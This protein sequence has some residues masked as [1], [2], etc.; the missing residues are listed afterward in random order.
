MCGIIAIASRQDAVSFI[1]EGLKKLEYRGYD[2]AGLSVIED[3]TL[4][5]VKTVGKIAE[6][7]KKIN[8]L[9]ISSTIGIGHTRWATHGIPCDQNAHPH[10][11]QDQRFSIVHNGIIENYHELKNEL[12]K[13]GYQ[14]ASTT[15]S[16]VIVA[17]IQQYYQGD[18][19]STLYK[20][21]QK[22]KGSYAICALSIDEPDCLVVAKKDSPV[23]IGQNENGCF[24]ASDVM[25]LLDYTKEVYYLNDYEM[26]TLTSSKITFYDSEMKKIIK[27]KKHVPY[28]Q[29]T[30]KKEGYETYMLKEIFEQ[31]KA[32]LETLRGKCENQILLEELEEID[33]SKFNQVYYI[34]CGTAYHASL[35][36]AHLL[37]KTS[38]LPIKVQVAS[39]FRY[40]EPL[41]DEKTLCIFVSQSGETADTLAGLK[42]ANHL[43]ATT[44]AI[45]NVVGSSISQ[46]AKYTLYTR[47]GLEIA[48][49]STKAY[50]TQL[51]LLTLLAI[52]ISEKLKSEIFSHTQLLEDLKTIPDKMNNILKQYEHFK[53][54]A[55]YLKESTDAYFIG[56][57]LDYISS[58]EGALKL[59]EISYVHAEAYL[60]GEL[61]HGPIALIE[62]NTVVFALAL[63]KNI[64][65]KTMS[66]IQETMARG[67]NVILFTNEP[68]LTHNIKEY[69]VLEDVH[70][71]LQ[72]LLIALPLQLIA[73]Y[74]ALIKECDVDQPR[75]LAKSVTV[76]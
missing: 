26:A 37:E 35:I 63:Q 41:I 53:H 18:L 49:A 44:I 2:S 68:S 3:R 4:K 24:V 28:N 74:T 62:P 29:E 52:Y 75:N 13:N 71:Y 5:T 1:V 31:P 39:E 72:P 9:P 27:D 11:S 57:G 16:E 33:F 15:D 17:L 70:P 38:H 46:E 21:T 61:K 36:G 40:N 69:Y 7:K 47:A 6:L 10:V 8:T 45:V 12:L 76:E 55:D 51:V 34:G 19:A 20:V 50:T 22:I 32:V 30:A 66:N 14:F 60:A 56:R 54:Y 25:A 67:A 64:N 58:L 48:V 65:E 59:K 73:Y 42:L 43:N 23:V